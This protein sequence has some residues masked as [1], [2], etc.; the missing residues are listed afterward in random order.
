MLIA[1]ILYVLAGAVFCWF[2]PKG[3]VDGDPIIAGID[4]FLGAA[5]WPFGV[6][7]YII[8]WRRNHG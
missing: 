4:L 6:V 2:A 3:P 7:G 8:Q 5:L 1:L